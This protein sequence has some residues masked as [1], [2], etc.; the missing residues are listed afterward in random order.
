[1]WQAAGLSP[2][3]ASLS[4]LP[5]QSILLSQQ[6]GLGRRSH[7]NVLLNCFCLLDCGRNAAYKALT[8]RVLGNPCLFFAVWTESK[9]S[10]LIEYLVG[11]SYVALQTTVRSA[12]TL[13]QRVFMQRQELPVSTTQDEIITSFPALR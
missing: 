10:W 4:L 8:F 12:I 1:M 9:F 3:G 5:R 11:I 7:Q 6:S 13:F 2:N